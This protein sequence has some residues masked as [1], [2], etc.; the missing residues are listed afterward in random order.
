MSVSFYAIVAVR[1]LQTLST[2]VIANIGQYIYS[3][4]L[5]SYSF[6]SDSTSNLTNST[7]LSSIDA[8]NAIS[9]DSGQCVNN[10]S[11]EADA[12]AQEQSADLFS[13]IGLWR[14][15]PI[16][17]MTC[18]L[19]LYVSKLGRRFVLILP[20][21]G[22]SIQLLIWLSMIY[23][24]LREYWWYVAGII[25]GFTGGDGVLSKTSCP[26]YRSTF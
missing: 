4:Y 19:G 8:L 5:Q 13:K 11:N 2:C 14:S 16:I 24:K 15:G 22:I 26:L 6:T 1:C 17:L 7:L 12:W 21:I 9:Q 3:I 23:F 10:I 25:L 18:V 20:M